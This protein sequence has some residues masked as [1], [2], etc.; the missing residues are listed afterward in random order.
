[1]KAG[2]SNIGQWGERIAAEYLEKTGYSILTRNYHTSTG[3]I[4]IIAVRTGIR[5]TCLVFV[6]VKTRTSHKYGYPEEAIGRKKWDHLQ[7]AIQQYLAA[8]PDN[9]LEWCVDVVAITGHPDRE[10]P[11]IQHYE[12]VV[13]VDDRY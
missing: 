12:N 7:S 3:E 4:D 13:I 2:A 8:H 6:E 11:Q 9:Q 10:N 5:S 1:M